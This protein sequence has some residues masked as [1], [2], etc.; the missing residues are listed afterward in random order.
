M[1]L[2]AFLLSLCLATA[3]PVAPAAPDIA[4]LVAST[5][6][7]SAAAAIEAG[8]ERFVNELIRLTE[9]PAPPFG[10]RA[11]AE[12]FM[13][14][15]R[16][17]GLRDVEM[18]AEGNVMGVRPGS[19]GGGML[20]VLAHLDTVFPAGTDVRVRRDGDR[21]FAP[22]IGDDTR[23]LAMLLAIV[24]A[25]DAAGIRTRD[26]ILFVGNVGEEGEGDLRGVRFLLQRGRYR[27]RITQVIAI[28]GSD[29]AQIVTGA[30]GSRRYRVRFTGPGG[31]S[32]GAFGLVSPAFAMGNAMARFGKTPVPTS[33]RTTFNVGVVGGGTSVNS[34]P[35]EVF[36]T[37]DLRSESA[38]ELE[39]LVDALHAHVRAAVEE[40]NR[41]RS[42]A[43]GEVG[44]VFE[45]I[46]NRPSGQ[47]PLSAPLVQTAAAVVRQFGLTPRFA[48]GSTDANIPISMGIPAIAIGHGRAGRAHSLDEWVDVSPAE[49]S[50][51]AQ[52]LLAVVGAAAGAEPH[53]H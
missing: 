27:D 6:F 23:G 18:D 8:H 48:T 38:E 33:P 40:E 26:D 12:A 20:A 13:S 53:P 17:A 7:R 14:L 50:R 15:L 2:P 37:V 24:R 28:D 41:T 22:G 11:R 51:A 43:R 25:M 46:G 31:H 49:Y 16:E 21:L 52:L 5:P 30:L 39:R 45:P 35:T 32:Y 19:G 47:T 9:I 29:Q 1:R 36:M 10:E 42:T 4:A 44:A 3:Q 34:I